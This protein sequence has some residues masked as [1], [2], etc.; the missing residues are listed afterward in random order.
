MLEYAE[1][2]PVTWIC[3]IATSDYLQMVCVDGLDSLEGS[4]QIELRGEIVNNL[5]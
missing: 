3:P 1:D 4:R 5:L 2:G